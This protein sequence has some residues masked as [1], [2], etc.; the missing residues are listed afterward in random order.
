[1]IAGFGFGSLAGLIAA[2]A[3]AGTV[4]VAGLVYGQQI[5]AAGSM[6]TPAL[7]SAFGFAITIGLPAGG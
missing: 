1:V 4:L 2:V 5:G 6:L 7:T 3:G